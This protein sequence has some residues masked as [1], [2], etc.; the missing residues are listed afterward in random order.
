VTLLLFQLLFNLILI[1]ATVRDVLACA[2]L[3]LLDW[4]HQDLAAV[5]KVAEVV[6]SDFFVLIVFTYILCRR[7]PKII[8]CNSIK[9]IGRLLKL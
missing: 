2:G 4:H 9:E 1:Q 5:A 7:D 8:N 6:H 3:P